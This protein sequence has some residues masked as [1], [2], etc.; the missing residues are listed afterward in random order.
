[1]TG[2]QRYSDL[3]GYSYDFRWAGEHSSDSSRFD[4]S[5]DQRISKMVAMDAK[6]FN[7]DPGEQYSRANV[8]RELNKAFLGFN[9][10]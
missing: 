9:S 2:F 1:M 10:R 3:S 5:S 8:L 7:I 6:P 4:R